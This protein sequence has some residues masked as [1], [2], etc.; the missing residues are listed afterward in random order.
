[1]T[2]PRI[3]A[4]TELQFVV[5]QKHVIEFATDGMPAVLST[6]ILIG[7]LERTAR[8]A[9][10]PLLETGE[11]TVGIEVELRHLAAT[12]L[13]QKVTCSARV[14]L[15]EGKEVTFQIE[16][17]DQH[18]LIARGLHKRAVIRIEN[19]SRRLLRKRQ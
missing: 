3:G 13:G 7:L 11:R 9:L 14:I 1:M 8:E 5:E 16:A 15:A 4:T 12:P 10:A 18:E 2:P 6:P 19:F 17:R